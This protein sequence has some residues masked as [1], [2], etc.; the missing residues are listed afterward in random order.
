METRNSGQ[1]EVAEIWEKRTFWQ[2]WKWI[3]LAH[4]LPAVE[5]QN[6]A[7]PRE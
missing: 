7:V 1:S 6:A 5:H 2:R 3:L 4:S